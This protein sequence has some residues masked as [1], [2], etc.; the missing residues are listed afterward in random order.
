MLAVGVGVHRH[1]GSLLVLLRKLAS[2]LRRGK[3]VLARILG[4]ETTIVQALL[5]T[6]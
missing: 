2:I 4:V 5:V 3:E 6:R 1:R